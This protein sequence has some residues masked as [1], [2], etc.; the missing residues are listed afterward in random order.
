MA[1]L[2]DICDSVP[3]PGP[4]KSP[5]LARGAKHACT[6]ALALTLTL[7]AVPISI[8]VS[9]RVQRALLAVIVLN[10]SWQ[11]QK[12]FF[13]REDIASLGSLGGLQISLTTIALGG[14]Y[15][16][17]L[18]KLATRAGSFLP[19]RPDCNQVTLPAALF[20]LICMASLFVAPDTTLGIFGVFSVLERFLLYLYIVKVVTSR[21][22]AVFMVRLLLIGLVVQSVVML[23]Q[24]GGLMG[25]IDYYGIKA[26]TEFAG[27]SRISGTIGSPNPAAAYLAMSMAVAFSVL[28]SGLR[29][30]DK[31]LAIV[32]LTTA[33]LPMIF[34]LSRGGWVSLLVS[35]AILVA[36]GGRRVPRKTVGAVAFVFVFLA[37]P[38][39]SAIEQRLYGDDNGSI[40]SRMP[41]NELASVMIQDHPLLGVGANNFSVAMQ[42]YLAHSFSGDFLY[43][44]HNAYL[45]I[46]AETGVVGLI[47]FLWFLI[48]IVHKGLRSRKLRDPSTTLPALGCAAAVVGFMVQMNFDPFRSAAPGL[49]L[50]LLAGLV[51]VLSHLPLSPQSVHKLS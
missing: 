50:W 43:A 21:E 42:P 20:L 34:T 17:W 15:I 1:F 48:A 6:T 16:A 41:L 11:I 36:L 47:A 2:C 44:V 51:T 10:I 28:L 25:D 39:R 33:I 5:T 12:H 29:W 7:L 38:F 24:A 22:D 9:R 40:A 46:C 27:D 23:A 31:C 14:L 8:L 13:L 49:L 35:F 37:I 19:V 4:P 18:I 30:P 32:G 3:S 26:R 45:L